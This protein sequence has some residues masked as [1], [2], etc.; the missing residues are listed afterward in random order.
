VAVLKTVRSDARRNLSLRKALDRAREALARRDLKEARRSILKAGQQGPLAVRPTRLLWEVAS[1][2]LR[3]MKQ[4]EGGTLDPLFN[5]PESDPHL[6]RGDADRAKGEHEKALAHFRA[7]LTVSPLSPEAIH[8]VG[9]TFI[10]LDDLTEAAYWL[11]LV[12]DILGSERRHGSVTRQ[13]VADCYFHLARIELLW[14]HRTRSASFA[15]K[16]LDV[17]PDYEPARSFLWDLERLVG[18]R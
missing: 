9:L 6:D 8:S 7:A 12:P 5:A 17:K 1:R 3:A 14:G 4:G 2:W 18:T 11:R 16:S 13:L 15:L 10:D